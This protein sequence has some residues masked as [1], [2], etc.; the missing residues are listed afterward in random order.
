MV[1]IEPK[2]ITEWRTIFSTVPVLGRVYYTQRAGSR[3]EVLVFR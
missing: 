3:Y 2:I 1:R